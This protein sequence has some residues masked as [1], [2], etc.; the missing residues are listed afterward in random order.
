[1]PAASP[2]RLRGSAK[3]SANSRRQCA[4]ARRPNNSTSSETCSPGWRHWPTSSGSRSKTPSRA[5]S[6][7]LPSES[8]TSARGLFFVHLARSQRAKC[9]KN[10]TSSWLAADQPPRHQFFGDLDG[11]ERRALAQIVVRHKECEPVLFGRVAPDAADDRWIDARGLD[12]R[13]HIIEHDTRS[14]REELACAVGADR[15]FESRVDRQ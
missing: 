4:R 3:N 5:T 12:G 8:A 1:M 10:R 6:T 14:R 13:R 2:P 7:I 15:S 9:T 11:V